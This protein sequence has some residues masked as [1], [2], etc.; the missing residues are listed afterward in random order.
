LPIG[1]IHAFV[2]YTSSGESIR[3][4]SF[5]D[6]VPEAAD[7]S[8]HMLDVD[9]D[10]DLDTASSDDAESILPALDYESDKG[11][12]GTISDESSTPVAIYMVGQASNNSDPT[13]PNVRAPDP[14]TRALAGGPLPPPPPPSDVL[15]TPIT[16]D[17]AANLK[18]VRLS[19]RAE[20]DRQRAMR[21]RLRI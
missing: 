2:G 16:A 11:S 18:A 4:P 20:Q 13:D 14:S 12:I 3:S 7:D 1:R 17:M 10:D 5:V 15:S 9:N 8:N 21:E 19:L 6:L